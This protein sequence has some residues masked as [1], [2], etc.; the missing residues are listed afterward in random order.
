[1]FFEVVRLRVVAFF[2]LLLVVVLVVVAFFVVARNRRCTRRCGRGRTA[3]TLCALFA[4][5]LVHVR[6]G[7]AVRFL[8]RQDR[9]GWVL[10]LQRPFVIR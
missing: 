7:L 9:N 3:S 5:A 2:V 6:H 1:M 10:G 4:P 8:G